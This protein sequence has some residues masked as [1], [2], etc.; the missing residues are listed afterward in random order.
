M[1]LFLTIIGVACAVLCVAV[2]VVLYCN[3]RKN[4]LYTENNETECIVSSESFK[5]QTDFRVQCYICLIKHLSMKYHHDV[6]KRLNWPHVGVPFYV[7]FV[8]NLLAYE[9]KDMNVPVFL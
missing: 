7:I 5:I 8:L 3:M 4:Y 1:L 2:F 9:M 6:L